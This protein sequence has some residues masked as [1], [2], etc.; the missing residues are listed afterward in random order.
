MNVIKRTFDHSDHA[1]MATFVSPDSD[2]D[3]LI[4]N[5]EARGKA[6]GNPG[7]TGCDDILVNDGFPNG[8]DTGV[9][10]TIRKGS[11]FEED[12]LRP[13]TSRLVIPCLL[14]RLS[15]LRHKCPPCLVVAV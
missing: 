2:K 4:S 10:R 6:T 8:G 13:T 9:I 7:F 15:R 3:N 11:T 14:I 5:M 12:A 1:S